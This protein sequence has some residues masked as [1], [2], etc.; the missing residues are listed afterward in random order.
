MKM[1]LYGFLQVVARPFVHLAFLCK[2]RFIGRE[3]MP[4]EGPVILCCNHMSY[5]DVVLLGLMFRRKIR[6]MGKSEL[7]EH[8]RFFSWLIRTLGCFPVRRGTG[9]LEAIKTALRILK[10]NQVLGIFPEGQR[11]LSEEE[12]ASAKAGV[13]ML[14]YKSRATVLPVAIATKSGRMRPFSAVRLRAGK[15]IP[16][17]ELGFD[18]RGKNYAE[19]SARIMEEVYALRES[20]RFPHEGKKQAER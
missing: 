18:A 15:A 13:A 8:G 1:R 20:I 6:F 14:A 4:A 7:F 11:N 16:V 9:D 19:V 12:A 17:K 2:I 10:D 5:F 3:N